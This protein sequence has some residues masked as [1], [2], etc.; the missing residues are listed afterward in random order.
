MGRNGWGVKL[1]TDLHAV[2]SSR[3]AELYL[4]DPMYLNGLVLN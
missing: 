3:K 4:H 1:T 2:P